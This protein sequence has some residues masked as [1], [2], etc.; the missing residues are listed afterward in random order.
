MVRSAQPLLGRPGWVSDEVD[1]L[2]AEPGDSRAFGAVWG[3]CGS[4]GERLGDGALHEA[5]AACDRAR[6]LRT[7]GRDARGGD[8]ARAQFHTAALL[9]DT[10]A[11]GDV[12]KRWGQWMHR[13]GWSSALLRLLSDPSAVEVPGV[14]P[15]ALLAVSR[16]V[17]EQPTGEL[18]RRLTAKEETLDQ[19]LQATR[20]TDAD[21]VAREQRREPGLP[22]ASCRWL[23]ALAL[24][25]SQAAVPPPPPHPLLLTACCG[26]LRSAAVAVG[27]RAGVQPSPAPKP[28]AIAEIG[29]TPQAPALSP[30]GSVFPMS[31]C[32]IGSPAVQLASPK[33]QPSLPIRVYGDDEDVIA[34]LLGA[35]NDG[36]RQLQTGPIASGRHVVRNRLAASRIQRQWRYCAAMRLRVRLTA[37]REQQTDSADAAAADQEAFV[38]AA[39]AQRL[40]RRRIARR[41][42][43]ELRTE[44]ARQRKRETDAAIAAEEAWAVQ[45]LRR[46]LLGAVDR[47]RLSSMPRVCGDGEEE[48]RSG[49]AADDCGND[50][51]AGSVDEAR[52]ADGLVAGYDEHAMPPSEE[53]TP[54][55]RAVPLLHLLRPLT[56][57]RHR[58]LNLMI[59]VRPCVRAPPMD[60]AAVA[61]SLI[62]VII[63]LKCIALAFRGLLRCQA[64][65]RAKISRRNFRRGVV[66]NAA[67]VGTAAVLAT[68][69]WLLPGQPVLV[70]DAN[71]RTW[72]RGVVTEPGNP[73]A[74]PS[75]IRRVKITANGMSGSF[76]WLQVRKPSEHPPATACRVIDDLLALHGLPEEGATDLVSVCHGLRVVAYCLTAQPRCLTDPIDLELWAGRK[77]P[78]EP[79]EVPAGRLRPCVPSLDVAWRLLDPLSALASL[80]PCRAFSDAGLPHGA[81][82]LVSDRSPLTP[83]LAQAV[84]RWAHSDTVT[85]DN[86]AARLCAAAARRMSP[87]LAAGRKIFHYRV[88]GYR[89]GGLRM[90]RRRR[91][92]NPLSGDC[93]KAIVQS[94]CGLVA[95]LLSLLALVV[96]PR[97]SALLVA[98]HPFPRILVSCSATVA[99]SAADSPRVARAAEGLLLAA[100]G[101]AKVRAVLADDWGVYWETSAQLR[102]RG[103][104]CEEVAV[105][106]ATKIQKVLR[107]RGGRLAVDARLNLRARAQHILVR[108]DMELW[109]NVLHA[110]KS[111]QR[112]VRGWRARRGPPGLGR[113]ARVLLMHSI[114]HQRELLQLAIDGSSAI[115]AV[116]R[117]TA[118]ASRAEGRARRVILKDEGMCMAELLSELGTVWDVWVTELRLRYQQLHRS[119]R[120]ADIPVAQ[121]WVSEEAAARAG[122]EQRQDA[123]WVYFGDWDARRIRKPPPVSPRSPALSPGKTPRASPRHSPTRTSH[124]PRTQRGAR[125][126]ERLVNAITSEE[127]SARAVQLAAEGVDRGMVERFASAHAER[128][129]RRSTAEATA[130]SPQRRAAAAVAASRRLTTRAPKRVHVLRSTAAR[131]HLLARQNAAVFMPAVEQVRPYQFTPPAV[132]PPRTS[133]TPLLHPQAGA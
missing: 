22:A 94:H 57:A 14:T 37:A 60:S 113:A 45:C 83:A 79:P 123:V 13:R 42:L 56:R 62:A 88:T 41:R 26:A 5:L 77:V 116:C 76:R 7:G 64:V 104:V 53:G 115:R 11:S 93:R 92:P 50:P 67:C 63:G 127:T 69:K 1:A 84:R 52:D 109:A 112:V 119:L 15:C 95:D 75:V 39:C 30:P 33:R 74:W 87:T 132:S 6:Q 114:A 55:R 117:R 4:V 49:A 24:S 8:A 110:V 99:V 101:D 51:E 2:V 71:G 28:E 73:E 118:S 68:A 130:V 61:A 23:A 70:R 38:A 40:V 91:L 59:G 128:D 124:S 96:A 16:L 31:F 46:C 12:S 44:A 103:L 102:E 17:S 10:V 48:E 43:R 111:I 122:I 82:A 9:A 120:R 85:H 97:P 129:W 80:P 3:D 35:G 29:V 36:T 131:R 133:V 81:L 32:D 78:L 107:G 106:A 27:L 58:R 108:R 54:P 105:T 19:L 72:R 65:V 90:V 121:L 86:A 89:F 34:A 21:A 125:A 126:M 25:G 100:T 98:P 47:M 66:M 20:D 18:P